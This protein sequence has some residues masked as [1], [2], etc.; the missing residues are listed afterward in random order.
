[1]FVN[2]K[3]RGERDADADGDHR[4]ACAR[5]WRPCPAPSLYLQAGPGSSRRRAARVTH[6]ISTPSR[7]TTSTSAESVG[8]A[9]VRPPAEAAAA[10]RRQQRSADPRASGLADDR[11]R[12]RLA[13][14]HHG[15]D[16]RRHA[17]RRLRPAARLDDVHTRSTSITWSWRSSREFWQSPDGLRDIY[18]SVGHRRPGSAGGARAL[19]ALDRAARRQPSGTVP[20]RDDLLQSAAWHCARRRGRCHRVS[21]SATWA[22]PRPCVGAFRAR[23]RPTSS[24]WPAEPLLIAAALAAVY[25]VLGVLYESYVH[26]LTILSTLPSAGV[27][28]LLALMLC[29]TELTVIALDRHHPP[30][31]HREE[32]RDPDD[33]L[34]P[35]GRAQGRQARQ[36]TPSSRRACCGSARSS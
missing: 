26:P 9:S 3:P 31:R 23:R 21:R 30:H 13:A 4:T 15:A 25:I 22:C 36:R 14:R 10:R 34:R 24:R 35:R 1:M 18:V 17:L 5:S 29:R 33:R 28:A 6:S 2:L 19:R 27:G 20:F 7:A 32:E 16:D 8:A 12:H 11:S